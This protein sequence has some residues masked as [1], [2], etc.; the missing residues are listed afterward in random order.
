MNL[1]IVTNHFWPEEF[2]INDLALGLKEKGHDV[3]VITGI[4]NYPAGRFFAG[5]GFIRKRR[6]VYQ[7]I[8]IIRAP[9]IPRGGG[10]GIRLVLNYASYALS[11]CLLA[12]F[13]CK[14][15]YDLILVFETSPITVGLPALVLKKLRGFP[16]I[17]WVQ[18][19]WPETLSATGV[20]RSEKVLNWVG[21]LV[22]FIYRNCDRILIQ[23]K[24]FARSVESLTPN[25]ECVRYFPNSAEELYQPVHL[26]PDATERQKVPQGFR[27]MFAGNLGVAQDFGTILNAAELLKDFPDIQWIIIGDGRRRVWVEQEIKKRDLGSVVHLLGRYPVE[28]MPRFF[29]LADA[30]LVTLKNEPIFALTIPSKIQSYLACGK[31]VIACLNGEGARVI[32]ESG[33]GIT[34]Q[35]ESP[36]ELANAVLQM[37]RLSERT[38]VSM[39]NQGRAYYLKEFERNILLDRL[40]VMMQEVLSDQESSKKSNFFIES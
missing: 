8:K 5:Y 25:P 16:I 18:D 4:P 22:Q 13:V 6:E 7:G 15:K 37:Y 26:P 21:R 39:G 9:L 32:D 40:E 31:P 35:A 34:C 30:L 33:A 17:F 14:E 11:A 3:S 2:R 28:S 10:S 24:A 19:L 12:P 1:L 27:V 23:S 29:S 20:V 38:R 36:Q